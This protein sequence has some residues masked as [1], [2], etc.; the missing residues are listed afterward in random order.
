[1]RTRIVRAATSPGGDGEQY[2]EGIREPLPEGERVLWQG[3]PSWRAVAVRAF[4][5]RKVAVYFGLLLAWRLASSLADGQ[6]IAAALSGS[7]AL[8]IVAALGLGLLALLAWLS[9][10]TTIYAI[11]SR[12]VML[13]IGIALPIFVN[14][15]FKGIEGAA[16]RVFA[17]GTGDLPLQLE[18]DVRLAYLHL[19]PHARPW[20]VK[21]PQPMLRG[22]RDPQRV[23]AVLKD[24][25][26]AD[27]QPVRRA[28][29]LP[30][31][32][33]VVHLPHETP[34]TAAA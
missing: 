17:D 3:A 32:P 7:T 15:P 9:A 33:R 6:T 31:P 21:Q 2:I 22:L 20:Q 5:I 23:A 30:L 26:A 11:T 25:I 18:G 14:L 19:W 24:A 28:Q 8:V 10:R 13:R 12:R 4:H 1:M 27:A 34:T 16:L 29:V